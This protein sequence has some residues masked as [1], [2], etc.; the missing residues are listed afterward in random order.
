[1]LRWIQSVELLI[2]WTYLSITPD[3][4]PYPLRRG[5]VAPVGRKRGF[6]RRL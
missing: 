3:G 6:A 5:L 1:M 4:A 2:E